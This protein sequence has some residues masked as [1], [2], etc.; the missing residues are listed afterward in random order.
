MRL[1]RRSRPFWGGLFIVAAGLEL[2]SIPLAVNAL[3]VAVMFGR[4]GAG[5]LIALTLVI[6]GVLVWLQPGQR[7]FLGLVSVL[8]SMASFVYSNL[9]GFLIGMLMGL[10]GGMLTMA[11]TPVSLPA[12]RLDRVT[13][14]GLLAAA[15][16]APDLLTATRRKPGLLATARGK[17][18]LLATARRKPGV[19]TATRQKPGVLAATGRGTGRDV[20]EPRPLD[21]FDALG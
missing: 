6:A 17:P 7:M 9:G 14:R 4:V 16:R 19:L 5:F 11:W 18:G 13:V 10:L 8:L 12:N 20:A 2:L 15:R 1:W 21:T 3:P